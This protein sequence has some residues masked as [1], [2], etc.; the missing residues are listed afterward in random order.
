M[1]R[2]TTL[3]WFS[4]YEITPQNGDHVP[5]YKLGTLFFRSLLYSAGLLP[6]ISLKIRLK[7]LAQVGSRN[8]MQCPAGLC[9]HKHGP[10]F[11]LI[12]SATR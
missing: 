4:R 5:V 8:H 3:G 2:E 7:A 9:D 6:V 12:T 10:A 1:Y 11:S